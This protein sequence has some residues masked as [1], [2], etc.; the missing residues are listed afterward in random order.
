M[1]GLPTTLAV[2]GEPQTVPASV[3]MT[4]YRVVDE[5]LASVRGHIGVS[6]VTVTLR[7]RTDALEVEIADDGRCRNGAE[8][9]RALAAS[10]AERLRLHGGSV[11][12]TLQADGT[13]PVNARIPLEA[14]T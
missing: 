5:A 9:A 6:E 11:D 13:C 7:W 8:P 14:R 1:R 4:A 3:Q 2:E 12:A 10:L